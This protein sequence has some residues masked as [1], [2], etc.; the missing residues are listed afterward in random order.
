MAYT[1]KDIKGALPLNSLTT[2]DS[3]RAPA[4][5]VALQCIAGGLT[6]VTAASVFLPGAPCA[7]GFLAADGAAGAHATL[8]MTLPAGV[9]AVVIVEGTIAANAGNTLTV[10]TGGV[11]EPGVPVTPNAISPLNGTWYI[12]NSLGAAAAITVET[13]GGD[14]LAGATAKIIVVG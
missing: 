10:K 3:S 5:G 14:F 4:A 12:D 8:A 2:V 13:A 11:A 1:T 9:K 7:F 6:G